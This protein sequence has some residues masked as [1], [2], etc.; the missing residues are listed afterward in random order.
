MKLSWLSSF[1]LLLTGTVAKTVTYDFNMEWVKANPDGKT[2]RDVLGINGQWPL[3]RIEVD[4]GDRLVV[5]VHNG[6]KHNNASIHFHGMYQNGTTHMDGPPGLTQ[7]PIPPGQNFT[8]NFTVNQNGTYWYHSHVSEQYPDGYR[9]PF[10]VHDKDAPFADDYDEELVVT[11]SDWYHDLIEDISPDFLSLYNPSGAE[12][13]PESMLFNET[14]ETS[15]P[16]E[17]NKTYL[18]H[19]INIGAFSSFYFFIED[20]DLEIV[21]V[22]GI[23]T[24]RK[25]TDLLYITAAQRYTVLLKTKSNKDKNYPI[26]LVF[27]SALFDVVDPTLSLNQTNWLEYDKDKEHPQAKID[28][29]ESDDFEPFDD[30]EL[31]PYDKQ[32]L[33]PDPD[34]TIEI[35]VT[36][37]NLMDGINYAFFNNITYTKPKVPTL[38]TLKSA[39]KKDIYDERIYGDY[40]HTYILKKNEVVEVIL[41]NADDGTHPFHLHGHAFQ[42][43][44]RSDAFDD[45]TD[46]DPNN[47]TDYPKSPM[48]RDTVYVNG[49]GYM[50]F[51]FVADNPGVWFFHCHIEWHLDQGLALQFIEAPEDL[52]DL[53]IP[54]QHYDV[55]KATN[56]PT[57]GNAAGNKDDF[58]NLEGQ[59]KQSKDLPPGMEARGIV[60]LVFSCVSAFLGMAAIGWYG[61]SDLTSSDE[62]I[63]EHEAG[64]TTEQY[65]QERLE[66][67]QEQERLG[68][69][70]AAY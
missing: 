34:H 50:V 6:L 64:E 12:P 30:M 51:R 47:R 1:G 56:Q 29:D 21:E 61:L 14:Q 33:L 66:Q 59:N 60:A 17:P 58:F 39:K 62:A 54:Q 67:E 22:D 45:P 40:T 10:I 37:N 69:N 11:M 8:Y 43:I 25:K 52:Y 46:F 28:V 2:T 19:L 24:E 53:D 27:D 26:A 4:K 18:L 16:V 3:P 13:V 57:E 7:C 38:Y 70:N 44:E 15:I 23:Y 65:E 63:F 31:V 35:T 68:T 49:N 48:R 9:A 55:C 5:N 36:M 32:E 20:H 41:N 42:V